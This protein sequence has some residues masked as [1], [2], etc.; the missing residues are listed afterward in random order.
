MLVKN[1][2][3]DVTT[4]FVLRDSTNHA[5]KTDVGIT[6]I[7][8][9][10]QE[11]LAAQ[12]DKADA[13]ALDAANSAHADN[14]AFHCG[15]GIYRVDW[16]DAAFDGGVGK[17]V[18]LIVV[19]SG[20]DTTYLECELSA[21]VDVA[22]ISTDATAADNAEAFFDG[23]GYAG[24]NNVIPT[25]TTLTNL[26]AVTA[27]WLTA[28][29][30]K[31]DAVTKIQSGLALEATLT[32]IK[33]AGWSTET[34]AALDVL[35]DAIK[36]KTD[37]IPASPAAVGSAMTLDESAVD[38]IWDE[39]QSGH[40]G[41]DT[42]GLYLDG[43]VSEAGGGGL[44]EAGI[45]D[46]VWDEILSGHATSGSGG[47][48]LTTAAAASGGTGAISWTINI[49]KAGVPVD[50]AFVQVATDSAFASVVASGYTNASGQVTFLLDAG[51][52]YVRTQHSS[53]SWSDTTIAVA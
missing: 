41:A 11:E 43:K 40:V 21:P 6:D 12:S 39:E 10:Y 4:Y 46:A 2:S 9:Y 5:P 36:A 30:V 26:P 8:L 27:D 38:A 16:P 51:T 23:T 53:G 45:A 15:N 1:A 37:L 14:K 29:G 19:C 47:K 20:V 48:L 3:T 49:T 32:A 50:G 34:L 33:G 7:D 31:A 18:T 24:T 42:F 44:T 52:Y 13:T 22:A 25:V 35:L 28:A 17:K